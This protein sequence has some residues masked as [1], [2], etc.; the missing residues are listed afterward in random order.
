MVTD[1]ELLHR[2]VATRDEQ[3]FATLVKRHLDLVYSAALRRTNGRHALAEEIAQKVFTDLARHSARLARHPTLVGWLHRSTRNKAIDAIRAEQ[4][5][6]HLTQT[7][8]VMNDPASPTESSLDW[9]QLR[10]VI[11]TSLDRIKA[12]D[13]EVILLRFFQGLSFREIGEQLNIAENT[14]RMRTQRALEKLRPHLRKHG[15][16]S[17]AALGAILAG[18]P[19]GATP[20][21]LT[22][23]I[24][25]TALSEATATV[26][27][28]TG[29][30]V[31]STVLLSFS[32]TWGAW[33][34][35]VDRTSDAE[36]IALRAEN[37]HLIQA[38]AEAKTI[39]NTPT[40]SSPLV[41]AFA[42]RRQTHIGPTPS[43]YQNAGRA[44]PE[45]AL[46]TYFWALDT[47]DESALSQL[48]TY[49]EATRSRILE[50]RDALPPELQPQFPDPQ[51]LVVFLYLA[52]A[53]LNPTP[54]IDIDSAYITETLDPDRAETHQT[55][56][57]NGRG[58]QWM[59]TPDG[60]KCLVPADYI[61]VMAN[62]VLKNPLFTH[63][64]AN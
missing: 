21:G 4:R 37:A 5:R 9:E 39:P 56:Y 19:L 14:A 55:K 62:R 43:P 13:R 58:L 23:T 10:P 15:I 36:L 64:A 52:D 44:T 61:T 33:T 29:K 35:L 32:A 16:A 59:N 41:R 57:P 42:A 3:A 50:Y 51:S 7:L 22:S 20:A 48:F 18:Q 38:L 49:D 54:E 46:R 17:T 6:T 8:T 60:W 40:V 24:T 12:P 63:L 11:D 47:G 1:A 30:L 28:S 26:V 2:Y 53:M 27:L 45:D 34:V 25:A 31:V